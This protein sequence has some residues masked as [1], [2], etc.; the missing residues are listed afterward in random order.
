M[1]AAVAVWVWL[2]EALVAM[3]KPP[4]QTSKTC[5]TNAVL[6]THVRVALKERERERE[7]VVGLSR[8]WQE[9]GIYGRQ[10]EREDSDWRENV[11]A[12]T[13]VPLWSC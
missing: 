4:S 11:A 6:L 10:R 1:R 7:A 12:A 5:S 13:V 9:V 8:T 3:G 2:V